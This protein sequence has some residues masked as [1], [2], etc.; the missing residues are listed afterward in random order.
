MTSSSRTVVFIGG[1]AY[2]GSTLLNLLI[3]NDPHGLSCGEVRAFVQP[4]LPHHLTPRCGC[5]EKNCAIWSAYTNHVTDGVHEWL[6]DQ[7]PTTRV[8]VDSSKDI[9]W[10]RRNSARLI[11]KG[12]Q[13]FHLLIWK[14]PDE[15][16]RSRSKRG[17]QTGWER[18]WSNYHHAFLTAFAD[19]RTVSY[20]ALVQQP[21]TLDAICRYLGMENFPGKTAYWE[22]TQHTLF[23]NSSARIHLVTAES[24]EFARMQ[25]EIAGHKVDASVSGSLAHRSV[26]YEAGVQDPGKSVV[27][28]SSYRFAGLIREL[29]ARDVSRVLGGVEASVVSPHRWWLMAPWY[30]QNQ[31]QHWVRR[32]RFR[33]LSI[34]QL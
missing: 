29:E 34:M 12:Y 20:A 3:A 18:S 16:F 30:L 25:R 9:G 1:T 7:L 4:Y 2:S 6:F 10:I 31:F 24:T 13:V 14:T 8:L 21:D 17:Q 28:S 19:C 5:G 26:R 32:L 27:E 11:A 15:Y 22:R 33:I 23:G